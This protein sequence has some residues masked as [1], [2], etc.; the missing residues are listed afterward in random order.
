MTERERK[1]QDGEPVDMNPCDDSAN[2]C[3]GGSLSIDQSSGDFAPT[4]RIAATKR[5]GLLREMHEPLRFYEP[6]NA[7]VSGPKRLLVRGVP[8]ARRVG[9]PGTAE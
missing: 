2:L 8:L 6:G 7:F 3:G 5:I 9:L 4:A 1:P